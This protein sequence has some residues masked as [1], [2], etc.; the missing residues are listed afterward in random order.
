[1]DDV[2][3]DDVQIADAPDE[4]MGTAGEILKR[5]LMVAT[6]PLTED[7]RQ[8]IMDA[9]HQVINFMT[10]PRVRAMESGLRRKL[11]SLFRELR[12]IRQL[13][14]YR[15]PSSDS[16]STPEIASLREA[17]QTLTQ[18]T[19]ILME[20][21]RERPTT[22]A[23]LDTIQVA[24]M[25]GVFSVVGETSSTEQPG[26]ATEAPLLVREQLAM[27]PELRS[28]PATVEPANV[29]KTTSLDELLKLPEEV[30]DIGHKHQLGGVKSDN[31]SADEASSDS[32]SDDASSAPKMAKAEGTLPAQQD[33]LKK[34]ARQCR[35]C[36]VMAEDLRRV[37]CGACSAF[38][39]RQ[40]KSTQL[41][42]RCDHDDPFQCRR[43]AKCQWCRRYRYEH[44]WRRTF[45]DRPMPTPSIMCPA[46]H[47]T[48]GSLEGKG[49]K[50]EGERGS[51][52]RQRGEANSPPIPRRSVAPTPKPPVKSA[53]SNPKWQ[54][55]A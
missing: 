49:C 6:G 8:G 21:I 48:A 4:A 12:G 36:L 26:L 35:V 22:A 24:T 20:E 17:V 25:G 53:N 14:L 52:R 39:K 27:E 34:P 44:F 1:M 3:D 43:P 30:A 31:A 19:G 38:W 16:E 2:G 40:V 51:R 5:V 55:S 46:E 13:A 32:E 10:E 41:P 23:L 9:A 42:E 15:R 37:G 47:M 54:S 28:S 11:D 45:P 7:R 29:R 33:T 50:G 18:Q